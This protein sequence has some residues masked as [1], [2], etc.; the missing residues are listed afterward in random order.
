[1]SPCLP[2]VCRNIINRS[3]MHGCLWLNDPDVHLARADHNALTENEVRL[4]TAALWLVGG[5]TLLSDRFAT[6]APER[7]Q[8]SRWLVAERDGWHTRPL[9]FFEREFPAVWLGR[10]KDQAPSDPA[11]VLG[12]FNFADSATTLQVPLAQAGFAPGAAV[13]LHD[14]W[15]DRFHSRAAGT[16]ALEVPVHSCTLLRLSPAAGAL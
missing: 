16:L 10:R 2:K 1:M 11:C 5:L 9:D 3:Y 8:W 4:W 14:V 6:L 15:T 7:E 13:D 12:L